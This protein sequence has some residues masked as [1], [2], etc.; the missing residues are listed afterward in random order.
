MTHR[1][2]FDTSTLVGAALRIGSTPYQALAI[3]VGRCEL[4]A[5]EETLAEFERVL[6]RRK[7]DRYLD[8]DAREEF[9]ALVR[10]RVRLFS[11]PG[12]ELSSLRP[13]CRDPRDRQFLALAAAAQAE[14]VVSSDDDLLVLNPWRG[15]PILTAAEFV[16]RFSPR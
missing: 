6:K 16:A 5:S 14:L 15:I 9:A 2:V 10:S 1:V 12:A 8:R 11:I 4:C 3:A 7:F 13:K